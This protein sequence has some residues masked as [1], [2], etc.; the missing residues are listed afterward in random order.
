M[1][2]DAIPNKEIINFVLP[3][4]DSDRVNQDAQIHPEETQPEVPDPIVYGVPGPSSGVLASSGNFDSAQLNLLLNKVKVL[5]NSGA[6][7]DRII[8]KQ[9]ETIKVLHDRN[10]NLASEKS[11]IA[12]KLYRE[13]KKGNF[14]IC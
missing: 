7:K 2:P 14:Q 11:N 8:K 12:Q 5:T 1:F 10:H 4:R 9:H 13:Q 3:I 6:S